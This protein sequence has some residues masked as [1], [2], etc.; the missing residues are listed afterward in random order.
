MNI[1]RV[2]WAAVLAAGLVATNTGLR[3]AEGKIKI[4]DS[5]IN[6]SANDKTFGYVE[7]ADKLIGKEVR[8]SDDEKLGKIENLVIDLESGR[9]LYA[10][11][12]SGGILGAG[13]KKIAVAPAVFSDTRGDTVRLN[14]DKQKFHGAPEF[15]KDIDKPAEGAQAGFVKN[16]Y[17]YYGQSPWRQGGTPTSEGSFNNVHKANDLMGMK[18][19]NVSDQA[20]G[21]VDNLA[22]DLAAGRVVFV[23]LAPDR[24]LDLGNNL[25]AL[26]PNALTLS[27]DRKF[28]VSDLS[29]EKLGTAPHFAKESWPDLSNSTFASQ[30]YRFYGK[31]AYFESNSSLRPTGT[32]KERLYPEKK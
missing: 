15:T 20:M 6:A 19:H 22:V 24:S 28:L 14:V 32:E 1:Y 31:Q 27:A 7:R 3:A 18:I 8:S 11:V 25:Y 21:K 10:V 17:S 29:K 5:N 2:T 9:I 16:V 23:T 13:E 26:P 12:G 30:V 4:E